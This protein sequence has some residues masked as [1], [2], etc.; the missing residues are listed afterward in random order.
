MI[1][2]EILHFVQNDKFWCRWFI[3]IPIVHAG[4]RPAPQGMKRG[5]HWLPALFSFPP[6]CKGRLCGVEWNVHR[7]RGFALLAVA[8]T[9]PRPSLPFGF[10]QGRQRRG[11]GRF[12][13][14]SMTKVGIFIPRQGSE[15]KTLG[16]RLQASGMTDWEKTGENRPLTLPSP[17]GRGCLEKERPAY[18]CGPHSLPPHPQP[19]PSFPH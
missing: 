12:I 6:L 7:A 3:F 4:L 13:F 10:A 16:A 11:T 9:S 2:G 18:H 1:E 17:K 5:A 8:S 15:A 14:V 19:S